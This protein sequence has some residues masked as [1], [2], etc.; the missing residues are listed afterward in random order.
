MEG[1]LLEERGFIRWG[2]LRLKWSPMLLF[3]LGCPSAPDTNVLTDTADNTAA[4]WDALTSVEL[5]P[6]R[7]LTVVPLQDA[8]EPLALRSLAA[9]ALTAVIDGP[10]VL[11][12][13]P[14][15]HQTSAGF[16]ISA[17]EWPDWGHEERQ[18]SCQSGEA[19]IR[20]G[21]LV[22]DAPAVDVAVDSV[23]LTITVLT[24]AGT[25]Q[26][27]NADVLSENPLDYLRLGE[28]A[29]TGL[30]TMAAGARLAV[31]D[32]AIAIAAGSTLTL[33]DGSIDLPGAATALAWI[34]G[35]VWALTESGLWANGTTLAVS[36]LAMAIGEDAVWIGD[37]GTL[38]RIDRASQV[39]EA[40]TV[41]GA[42]GPVAIDGARVY[43]ATTDGIAVLEGG[44]EVARYALD[45]PTDI[46][47]GPPHEI[48]ALIDSEVHIFL[49]ETALEGGEPLDL[50]MT[51]FIEQPRN[52]L[53]DVECRGSGTTITTYAE[54]AVA[55]GLLLDDLP[56]PPTVGITPFFAQRAAECDLTKTLSP[57]ISSIESGV[58]FHSPTPACHDETDCLTDW[59]AADAD[60]VRALGTTP[61]WSSGLAAKD[62]LGDFVALLQQ[63]AGPDR[64]LFFG[65]SAL[66][67][68]SHEA[69]PRS[70][71][72]WPIETGRRSP[73]WRIDHADELMDGA[74]GGWLSVYPGDN[75]P[76]FNLGGCPNLQLRE[77][78]QLGL[79]GSSSI[80]TDDTLVLD[81]L[82]HRALADRSG[83]STFSFHLPDLGVYDYIAGCEVS[84]R[85]WSGADCQAAVLQQ[86]A[87]SVYERHVLSGLVRLS[88]PSSL[89]RPK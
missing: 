26:T 23:A 3:L 68:F 33:P 84:E 11:V 41:A 32:G 8:Q 18:G 15:Y 35:G 30:G 7:A 12:I 75:I 53:S 72:A 14:L 50:V 13:D 45:A 19:F 63:S 67:E 10:D 88:P 4:P 20:R 64:Y 47:A 87:L 85:I 36:G 22:P 55:N 31:S 43:A 9:R 17:A 77:C 49:D 80:D 60:Y 2:E 16:C 73:A 39:T 71:N 65:I 37:E 79:G 82:L 52:T 38:T 42:M 48:L 70:K 28:P 40:L 56:F 57:L 44:A 34:D 6:F 66:P 25:L 69:D 78:H 5:D 29:E 51:S 86:W 76:L 89:E 21:R 74:A 83:P 61:T 27:A 24:A 58:L 59:L 1:I 81:L 46:A 62:D 54:R